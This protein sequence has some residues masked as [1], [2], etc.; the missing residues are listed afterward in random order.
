MKTLK[1]LLD[2]IYQWYCT[3][4]YYEGR[5]CPDCDVPSYLPAILNS[6]PGDENDYST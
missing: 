6:D 5:D 2:H 1:E 4:G 3:H